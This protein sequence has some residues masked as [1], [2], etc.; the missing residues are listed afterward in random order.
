[1]CVFTEERIKER[2]VKCAF[3]LVHETCCSKRFSYW[4]GKECKKGLVVKKE[5]KGML[6]GGILLLFP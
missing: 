2:C 6:L 5:L 3:L 1:M 4:N